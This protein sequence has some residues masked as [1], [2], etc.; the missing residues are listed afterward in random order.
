VTVTNASYNSSG[1]DFGFVA[2]GNPDGVS[3]SCSAN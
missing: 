2:N 1:G 3:V